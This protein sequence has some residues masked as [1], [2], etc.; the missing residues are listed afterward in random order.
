MGEV[1]YN[2]ETGEVQD[3]RG[4]L[5]NGDIS[6]DP[7]GEWWPDDS[8]ERP[9]VYISGPMVCEGDPYVNIRNAVLAGADARARGW[10]IIVSHLDSI[11]AMITGVSNAKHYLDN[12]YNQIARCDAVLILP[13]KTA[14]PK[15]GTNRELDFAE[16][17]NIP[18]FTLETLPTGTE[19]DLQYGDEDRGCVSAA[20]DLDLATC[21]PWITNWVENWLDTN[22]EI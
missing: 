20:R 12:D 14:D 17:M 3:L 18:I 21:T 8:S 19:F 16:R 11:T 5:D 7:E 9:M 15:A 13:I 6:L 22:K 4:A 1:I 10:S 2:S